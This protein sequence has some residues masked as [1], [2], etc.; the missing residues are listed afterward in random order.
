MKRSIPSASE[1][2]VTSAAT[3]MTMP[4]VDRNVRNGLHR[5]VSA[6]IRNAERSSFM[7]VR[8]AK[9][10]SISTSI[11]R[12]RA[13]R[14]ADGHAVKRTAS[15]RRWAERASLFLLR[16]TNVRRV[17]GRPSA[18]RASSLWLSST[19]H[20]GAQGDDREHDGYHDEHDEE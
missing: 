7:D 2:I 10:M 13:R 20:R 6:L 18:D 1:R 3:P 19:H 9:V 16:V 12:S 11:Q 4:R 17:T 15:P 5:R 14:A 8:E